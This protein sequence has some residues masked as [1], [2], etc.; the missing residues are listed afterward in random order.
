MLAEKSGLSPGFLS[1]VERGRS[2]LSIVSLSSICKALGLPIE[3]LF[4][5]T[6][7]V[8]HQTPTVTRADQQLTIKIGSAPVSYRYFSGQLPAEP[9]RELLIAELPKGSKQEESAHEGEEFGFVLKGGL[10]L[11]VGDTTFELK[12]G[13]SYHIPPSQPHSYSTTDATDAR[14]LMAI[15]Q[16]FIEIATR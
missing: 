14:V 5:S 4:S 11:Q 12:A 1:Q 13:D 7:P 10:T 6:G 9:V 3:T 2:T 8:D 16:P 15:T